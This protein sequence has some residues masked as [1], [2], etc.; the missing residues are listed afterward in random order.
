MEKL[1]SKH[2]FGNRE[3]FYSEKK[4]AALIPLHSHDY[5]ELEIDANIQ[6]FKRIIMEIEE[7][8]L[9][10]HKEKIGIVYKNLEYQENLR[11]TEEYKKINL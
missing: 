4:T 6:A 1:F 2:Y 7:G 10:R 9:P 11:E 5:F 8:L 3:H